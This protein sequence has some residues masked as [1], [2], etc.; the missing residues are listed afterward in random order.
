MEGSKMDAFDLINIS[1]YDMERIFND[2]QFDL[3]IEWD[4]L[5]FIS[6]VANL[7]D[8]YVESID[9]IIIQKNNEKDCN[10]KF[11][12]DI[13]QICFSINESIDLYL[14]GSP[15][16]A[17]NSIDNIMRFLSKNE[18]GRY[19]KTG[20][21]K[22]SAD[23]L[24][25]YRVSFVN[26]SEEINRQKIFHVPYNLR[27]KISTCRYSIAGY[28][29][30]YLSTTPQ[31]ACKEIGLNVNDHYNYDNRILI[32]SKFKINRNINNGINA[33]VLELAIKPSDFIL[34]TNIHHTQRRFDEIN[35]HE[36]SVMRNYLFWY[37]VIAVSS[38]IRQDKNGHLA[39]EY[40][41][42][43]LIM[44]WVNHKNKKLIGDR[45]RKYN[46]SEEELIIP[47]TGIRYFSCASKEA[48]EMGFNYVF[49]VSGEQYSTTVPYCKYL[50]K[51]FKLTKPLYLHR[52]NSIRECEYALIRDTDLDYIG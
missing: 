26:E 49:P 37:P 47:M 17:Y 43:Q 23:P 19:Q 12:C 29:C 15:A 22:T 18:L 41:V 44:Q 34:N 27:N 4:G 16:L 38:Y 40:I 10:K 31:L 50:S 5:D 14:Q 51:A 46:V 39:P 11:L 20:F 35:L 25:L 48:S 32:A 21:L 30:L 24:D 13:K 36:E 42:P 6:N 52:Y 2:E 3:P 33:D 28:P 8:K 7:L 45:K 1:Q 9:R